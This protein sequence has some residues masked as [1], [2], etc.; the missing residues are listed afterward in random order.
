MVPVRILIVTHSPIL[1]TG[2][3]EVIRLVFGGLLAEFPTR[4]VV[5]QVGLHHVSAVV[6]SPW[7]VTRTDSHLASNGEVVLAQDDLNGEKTVQRVLG[8]FNPD[9]VFAHND[10]QNV[11]FLLKLRKLGKW[12]LVLYINFDGVPVPREFM[13]LMEANRL[14]TL[15]DFSR[16]AFLELF[17]EGKRDILRQ[18]IGVMY[19]PADLLRFRPFSLEERAGLRE[20]NFPGWIPVDAFVV[21]W[22]GRNQWRKQIWAVYEA[23]G[24]LRSGCYL[25]CERCGCVAFNQGR[26]SDGSS[27][28]A[29]T[30]VPADPLL[31][32]YLWMH[33]PTGRGGGDW[34]LEDLEEIYGAR[35]GRDVYYTQGCSPRSHL[36]PADMPALYG[37]WNA[38]L[39]PSGGEGFG[40]PAWEAMSSGLPV[41]Y[42]DYSSHAEFLRRADAGIPAT[43]ILQPEALNCVFRLVPRVEDL[44]AG[45]RRL[46]FDRGLGIRLGCNGRRYA[47]G[48]GIGNMA[49][50]WDE[51]FRATLMES[52][53]LY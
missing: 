36:A 30:Y 34:P 27:C 48:F 1:Y 53:G 20:A 50:Q 15:S 47:Q 9:I 29:C 4:Y 22:I 18:R 25:V 41:V 39:F 5:H 52:G 24:R 17:C 11:G 45:V 26:P 16:A 40:L 49:K 32:I 13:A 12:K 42:S 10:P 21:G 19:C 44:V 7:P 33:L 23:I 28:G 51:I 46:Y 43:G 38:L 14:I 3:A 37:M 35:A 6:D 8:E 2:M 31:D